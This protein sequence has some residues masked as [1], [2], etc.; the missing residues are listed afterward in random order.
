MSFFI[1]TSV[2]VKAGEK[3]DISFNFYGEQLILPYSKVD[4][5]DYKGKLNDESIRQFCEEMA[6]ARY[7]P[8][9]QALL[10]YKTTHKPDDWLYYQL[11]RN[12]AQAISP[13]ADD[14]NRYT[15]YKWYFMMASGYDATLCTTKDKV[16]FYVQSNDNIYDVPYRMVNG[17]Q[18]ICLNYHDYG[19]NLESLKDSFSE[20]NTHMLAATSSFSYK[21]TQLPSFNPSDYKEKDIVFNYNQTEYKFKV[22]LNTQVKAIFANY[23]VT[24]YESYFNV[25]L[26]SETYN[27]LIPALKESVRGMG[28]KTGVDYLM[29]F[30]RNAFL[31]QP[32]KQS[33]GKEKRLSAEQTLLSEYSDCEDRAA[34]FFYLVKEI[35]NLPMIVLAFPEHVTVAVKFDKPVGKPIIYNG[36]TYTVCEP[37]PQ[38]QDLRV[39]QLSKELSKETYEVAYVYNP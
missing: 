7:Q 14:Y 15:L 36:S 29:H 24:D 13:K 26:S 10:D 23:P 32:D 19:S 5:V 20:V 38:R 6:A 27:S 16:L 30:T 39:G 33:F 2:C 4:F 21:V 1:F 12:T 22:K 8:L 9:I 34:L 11:V 31:Y 35:Y 25:P 17:K 37:T 28:A 18:Y 3:N